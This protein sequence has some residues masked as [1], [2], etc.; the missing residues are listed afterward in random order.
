MF[1]TRRVV[2]LAC[3]I[4][5]VCATGAHAQTTTPHLSLDE[6]DSMVR[7]KVV[8][9]ITGD[10]GADGT[11]NAANLTKP[12]PMLAASMPTAATASVTK[13]DTAPSRDTAA[14]RSREPVSFVG[15]F[16]DPGGGSYV[17]YEFRKAVYH[18]RVGTKLING[19]NLKKVEGYLVTVAD[20]KRVWTEPI[21]TPSASEAVSSDGGVPRSIADLGGPLPSLSNIQGFAAPA[22]RVGR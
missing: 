22:N 5:S 4:G 12:Q 15:A 6:I 19:W 13:V 17:L 18:A 3:A 1:S 10:A 7:N 2:A 11:P 20:G 8:R 14:A 16:A 21:S 9:Q